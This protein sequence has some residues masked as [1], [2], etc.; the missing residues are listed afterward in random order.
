MRK[1]F[2][3][4]KKLLSQTKVNLWEL[5][6]NHLKH[7]LKKK[8]WNFL[9]QTNYNG[10]KVFQFSPFIS[11]YSKQR[12][13]ATFKNNLAGRKLVRL[14]YGR[15]K[16]KEFIKYFKKDYRYKSLISKLGSRLD[17]NL[18]LILGFSSIF[19]LRQKILH[20]KVLLNGSLIRSPNIFLKP[21]DIISLKLSDFMPGNFFYENFME[22][23]AFLESI[24][25]QLFKLSNYERL[26]KDSQNLFIKNISEILLP[27]DSEIIINFF[28]KRFQEWSVDINLYKVS[29]ENLSKDLD[30]LNESEVINRLKVLYLKRKQLNFLKTLK[31]RVYL[32]SIFNENKDFFNNYFR[33]DTFEFSFNGDY[34]DIVFLGFDENNVNLKTNEKYLL[35]YLFN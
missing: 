7:K 6:S 32:E 1:P 9:K 2:F 31:K 23:E 27:E 24:G 10:I 8:K 21:F 13:N 5:D 14:K 17:V 35:H 26:D 3:L 20:K 25:Y 29:S 28:S 18:C 4:K 34:L 16:N 12:L 19:S 15:L 30:L 33:R 22:K 11:K